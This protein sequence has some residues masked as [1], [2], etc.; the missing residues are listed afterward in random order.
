MRLDK[1]RY[2]IIRD[3][4]TLPE[5]RTLILVVALIRECNL[6][7]IVKQVLRILGL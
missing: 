6:R 3:I 7:V 1:L 4:L 5:S 2:R